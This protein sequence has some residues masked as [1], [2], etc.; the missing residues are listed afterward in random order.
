[1]LKYVMIGVVSV[2]LFADEELSHRNTVNKSQVVEQSTN[3]WLASAKPESNHIDVSQFS[4]L[5][6][7]CFGAVDLYKS[8]QAYCAYKKWLKQLSYQEFLATFSYLVHV[9]QQIKGVRA[10][11][12]LCQFG[13]FPEK[14]KARIDLTR[15]SL[16]PPYDRVMNDCACKSYEQNFDKHGRFVWREQ[17]IMSVVYKKFYKK[18]P[19][20]YKGLVRGSKKISDDVQGVYWSDISVQTKNAYNQTLL[21]M[22]HAGIEQNFPWLKKLCRNYYDS[23]IERLYQYYL[24]QKVKVQHTSYGAYKSADYDPIVQN[25]PTAIRESRAKTMTEELILRES[26]QQELKNW[27]L[28]PQHQTEKAVMALYDGLLSGQEIKDLPFRSDYRFILLRNCI[29]ALCHGDMSRADIFE[30]FF[31]PSGILKKYA[32]HVWIVSRSEKIWLHDE[33]LHKAFNFALAMSEKELDATGQKLCK[34]VLD[35][36][37]LAQQA[38]TK[39]EFDFCKNKISLIYEA[40]SHKRYD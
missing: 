35:I 26:Y 34:V 7:Y 31:L 20:D 22:I 13:T 17:D 25:L 15:L 16:C 8:F 28:L 36:V 24:D 21:D 1:M 9:E 38:R 39:E 5:V 12:E 40:L 29:N 11:L 30:D 18:V 3:I 10:L 37:F 2:A 14:I 32:N 19:Q 4:N 33:L 6:G 27:L 23:L